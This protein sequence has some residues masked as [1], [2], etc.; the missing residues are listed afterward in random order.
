MKKYK[1]F[2]TGIAVFAL[3]FSVLIG[4]ES[5]TN[6]EQGPRGSDWTNYL[7]IGTYG[8]DITVV[9]PGGAQNRFRADFKGSD[10]SSYV[11]TRWEIKGDGLYTGFTIADL[12]ASVIANGKTYYPTGVSVKDGHLSDT[13]S[14]SP[15]DTYVTSSGVLV[16]SAYEQA[17][18]VTITASHGGYSASKTVTLGARHLPYIRLIPGTQDGRTKIDLYEVDPATG[19]TELT[20][21]TQPQFGYYFV[22]KINEAPELNVDAQYQVTTKNAVYEDQEIMVKN[23]DWITVYEVPEDGLVNTTVHGLVNLQVH[24]TAVVGYTGY[25]DTLAAGADPAVPIPSIYQPVQFGKTTITTGPTPQYDSATNPVNTVLRL[26]NPGA[27]LT[28]ADVEQLADYLTVFGTGYT[29][30][31]IPELSYTYDAVK[32]T[33]QNPDAP[34]DLANAVEIP[35]TAGAS[36]VLPTTGKWAVVVRHNESGAW[37]NIGTS[38]VRHNMYALGNDQKKTENN[39]LNIT[40]IGG[41]KKLIDYTGISVNGISFTKKPISPWDDKVIDGIPNGNTFVS[42]YL[43]DLDMTAPAANGGDSPA[44]QFVAGSGGV[45]VSIPSSN[46]WVGS[47]PVVLDDKDIQISW[48]TDTTIRGRVDI[49]GVRLDDDEI[50]R[51]RVVNDFTAEDITENFSFEWFFVK[52]TAWTSTGKFGSVYTPEGTEAGNYLGLKVTANAGYTVY[53]DKDFVF[54]QLND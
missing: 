7:S 4:C 29:A 44:Q 9:A 21:S 52:G 14:G 20:V 27:G 48:S 49:A 28:E 5:P 13:V 11:D 18:T 23:G 46:F 25:P 2:L 3:L 43:G 24:T 32:K 54:G 16:I 30:Y 51:V 17:K 53:S 39:I 35:V 1:G 40:I 42:L 12:P 34:L 45:L 33:G 22:Y 31:A 41:D 6:G 36:V 19:S 38:E 47:K 50:S 10:V 15:Y 8:P 37:W 26:T